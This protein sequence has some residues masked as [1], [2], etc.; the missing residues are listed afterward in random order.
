MGLLMPVHPAAKTATPK[1]DCVP[2]GDGLRDT[3]APRIRKPGN[4]H[5][6]QPMKPSGV[7]KSGS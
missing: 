3:A 2:R 7:I 5:P 4:G 1:V 6:Q